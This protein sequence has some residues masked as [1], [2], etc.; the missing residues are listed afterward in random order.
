MSETKAQV[1]EQD[2]KKLEELKDIPTMSDDIFTMSTEGRTLFDVVAMFMGGESKDSLSIIERTNFT[3][4]DVNDIS[5]LLVTAKYGL[6]I[7]EPK[8]HPDKD[9]WASPKLFNLCVYIMRGRV[10]MDGKSREQAKEALQQIK[11]RLEA[12]QKPLSSV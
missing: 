12:Q 1:S 3:R 6:W 2:A 11:L 10:S 4:E 7:G 5:E 9:G 8:N